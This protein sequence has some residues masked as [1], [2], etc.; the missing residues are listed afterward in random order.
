MLVLV[1]SLVTPE[2]MNAFA[3]T[4]AAASAERC[5]SPFATYKVTTSIAKAAIASRV[6]IV[7]ATR[8]M[9]CPCSPECVANLALFLMNSFLRSYWARFASRLNAQ[10]MHS[11]Y[12]RRNV[13]GTPPQRLCKPLPKDIRACNSRRGTGEGEGSGNSARPQNLEPSHAVKNCPAATYLCQKVR[14]GTPETEAVWGTRR[15]TFCGPDRKGKSPTVNTPEAL[16]A[17]LG[18]GA[19][20]FRSIPIAACSDED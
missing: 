12:S 8:T 11:H 7:R 9:V 1:G 18:G 20:A 19:R 17:I 5:T 2:S 10:S 16:P 13:N 4:S 15:A 3:A 6:A 14:S